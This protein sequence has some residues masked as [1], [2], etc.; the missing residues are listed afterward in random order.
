MKGKEP[1]RWIFSI[2]V[3]SSLVPSTRCTFWSL[4]AVAS[5]AF[6]FVVGPCFRCSIRR[7]VQLGVA[8]KVTTLDKT[9]FSEVE[10]IG[11][12]LKN[13]RTSAAASAAASHAGVK[14]PDDLPMRP[15]V[16]LL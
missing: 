1:P 8:A 4:A 10:K 2:H 6:G 15:E 9:H 5:E 3:L 11:I 13:R 12:L 7:A 16:R 14:G